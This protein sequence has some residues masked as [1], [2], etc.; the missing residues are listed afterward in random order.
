MHQLPRNSWFLHWTGHQ[1]W[2]TFLMIKRI[3]FSI[4]DRIFSIVVTRL[5]NNQL[6]TYTGLTDTTFKRRI[7]A[8]S[9]GE[10][11]ALAWATT[12][13][14]NYN[15]NCWTWMIATAWNKF[16]VESKFKTCFIFNASIDTHFV[17][18]KCSFAVEQDQKVYRC[19]RRC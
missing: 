13:G 9:I 10:S 1:T 18:F 17:C 2:H 7:P 16:V 6:E 19:S 5:D 4:V 11:P 3:S 14:Y 15:F 8:S 12:S